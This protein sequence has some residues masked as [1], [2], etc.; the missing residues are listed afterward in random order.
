VTTEPLLH[1]VP[2][3]DFDDGAAAPYAPS[4]L[5][6]EGFVHCSTVAQV[7]G[8]ARLL[9][10]GTSDLLLLVVDPRRLG[11][12]PVRWED[13]YGTG[14]TFPHVYGAI[15]RDAIVEVRPYPPGRG[16]RWTRPDLDPL[17]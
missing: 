16:G 10:A 9:F 17:P 12:A 4:S 1:L 14:Q 15:P 7:A 13:T 5:A 2:A 8:T 3:A 11:D 6:V